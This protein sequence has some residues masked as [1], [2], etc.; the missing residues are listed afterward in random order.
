MM[1]SI[2]RTLM[3]NCLATLHS[4]TDGDKDEFY[5]LERG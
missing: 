3:K 2:T 5:E 4:G 1:R